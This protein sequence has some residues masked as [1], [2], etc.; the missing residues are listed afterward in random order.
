MLENSETAGEIKVGVPSILAMSGL[1][2]KD[3]LTTKPQA[4]IAQFFATGT[5]ADALAAN[6][7]VRSQVI[8]QA[9]LRASVARIDEE[10]ERE[11]QKKLATQIAALYKTAPNDEVKGKLR[12]KAQELN[13]GKKQ[14]IQ[15]RDGWTIRT[16][17]MQLS[18]HFEHTVAVKKGEAEILTTFKY[19]EEVIN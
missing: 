11:E 14:I 7:A 10:A 1:D 6:G 8:Q 12:S 13:L 3:S 2:F 17:D 9:F 19:I 15:E 16:A 18:A 5:A 4:N